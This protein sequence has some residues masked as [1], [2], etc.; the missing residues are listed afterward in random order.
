LANDP[1]ALAQ[2]SR[3]LGEP[4]LRDA[5]AAAINDAAA[6]GLDRLVDGLVTEAASSDDV[7]DRESALLFFEARL[8]FLSG[9]LEPNL[10]ARLIEALR[11]KIEAW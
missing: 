10:R 8:E 9:L 2:L 5:N 6:S 11:A 1:E 7:T 4:G 3:L